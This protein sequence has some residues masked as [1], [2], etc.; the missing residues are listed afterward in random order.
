[1][2]ILLKH[3][4][5]FLMLF[6][7]LGQGICQEQIGLRTENYSGVNSMLLNPAN[8]LTG[9]FA[10]DINLAS[11][12]LFFDNRYAYARNTNVLNFI[13]RS[14][15]LALI[16]DFDNESQIGPNDLVIDF[17]G[18]EG[19]KNAFL[20][21]KIMGPSF[22]IK[23]NTGHTF[24]LFTNFRTAFSAP[25]LPFQTSYPYLESRS[26]NENFAMPEFSLA[27]MAWAEYGMNY[28]ISFPTSTGTF[29]IGVNLKILQG[30]EGFYLR[31][32]QAITVTQLP[33]DT[34]DF[35]GAFIDF[36]Y[37]NSNIDGANFNLNKGGFGAGMDIGAVFTVD[38]YGDDD[39]QFKLGVSILDIGKVNFNNNSEVRSFQIG[40]MV[41]VPSNDFDSA[42]GTDEFFEILDETLLGP[43]NSSLAAGN[44]GLWLPAALS[45]QADYAVTKNFYVNGLVVQ[46][47]PFS[48]LMLQ[49]AS[50]FALSPRFEHRWFSASLPFVVHNW[51]D[52]RI[53]SS[54][55]L[56]FITLG[57]DNLTSI[58]SK[59]NFTGSDI[60]IAVKLNPFN[61]NFGGGNTSGWDK[62]G[63]KT[64][65]YQF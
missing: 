49:R 36:G 64:K 40:D 10:W 26:I 13:K 15:D 12:A 2:S 56:A 45:I 23:T 9:K 29:G 59:G 39:Y 57:T 6:I 7:G 14:D 46:P 24:G 21:T 27:G 35:S 4:F 1:M 11:A 30:Y 22:M 63:K 54:V 18:G 3:K 65:C 17:F 52:F 41:S 8:N 58:I 34:V 37:T 62:G 33:G 31:N 53:G 61:L 55:R 5:L 16:T 50:T 43:G 44:F 48:K 51:Q 28:G 19:K 60:Y 42:N 20:D 25:A 32:N 47:I 38:G